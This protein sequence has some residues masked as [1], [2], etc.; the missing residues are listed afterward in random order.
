[1][2]NFSRSNILDHRN[3][4][5]PGPESHGPGNI[6]ATA[7]MM[8]Q[9]GEGFGAGLPAYFIGMLT[10]M[11]TL[12]DWNGYSSGRWTAT[13]TGTGAAVASNFDPQGGVLMTAGS[14]TT[15]NTNL[16]GPVTTG[17][18]PTEGVPYM[19]LFRVKGSAMAT[20]LGFTLGFG[21]S[22]VDPL[23]TNYTDGFFFKKAVLA[24]TVVGEVRGNSGTA[25]D[26][27]TLLTMANDTMYQFGIFTI[28]SATAPQGLFAVWDQA[29]GIPTVTP[30]TDLQLAAL[31]AILTTPPTIY[32]NLNIKGASGNPTAVVN[33]LFA[34]GNQ[35]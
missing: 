24:A 26:T 3:S 22:Q 17:I 32:C 35:F 6:A 29:S 1:M 13:T 23:T 7:R 2:A 34:W 16:Q 11:F 12:Q 9:I 31:T 18:T 19:A 21:N 5:L 27:G 14:S 15:F 25:R 33:S 4:P 8:I 30:F 10:K 28:P 20:G